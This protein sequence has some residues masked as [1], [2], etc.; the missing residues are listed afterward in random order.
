MKL[1]TTLIVLSSL[2]IGFASINAATLAVSNVKDGPGD[3][4]YAYQNNT[5]LD[6]GIVTIG[7][8]ASGITQSQIDTVSELQAILATP[9]NY[10]AVTTAV[11]G[12]VGSGVGDGYAESPGANIGIITTGN[13]LLGRTIYSIVTNRLSLADFASGSGV[14]NQVALV[15]IGTFQNDV[16]SEFTYS[17]NP[18]APATFVIGSLGSYEITDDSGL[19]NGTYSTLQM[20]S[21]PEPTALLLSAF[22]ALALLRRKR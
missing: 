13:P 6:D 12:A 15:N 10:I 14:N 17:A 5:L 7:Y 9:S 21:I 19:G 4:L 2:T 3:T 11:P 20:A 1:K 22:G 18:Q 8:F 16:P